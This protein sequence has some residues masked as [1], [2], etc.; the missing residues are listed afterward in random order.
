MLQEVHVALWRSFLHFD[1]RCSLRTWVYRVA[2]NIATSR[3][4]SAK[5]K[6]NQ[7]WTSLEQ[8]SSPHDTETAVLERDA[9]RQLLALVQHLR[10]PD[11]QIVLLYLEGFDG[12]SIAEVTGLSAANVATKIHR[13]KSVLSRR[14]EHAGV[15]GEP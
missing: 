11:R 14:V 7:Q 2:H 5:R 13:L 10:P 4:L 15:K 3:A 9:L 1:G 6:R 12:A 8:L